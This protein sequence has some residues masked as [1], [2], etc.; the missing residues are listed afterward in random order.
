MNKAFNQ[1]NPFYHDVAEVCELYEKLFVFDDKEA[2]IDLVKNQIIVVS[3]NDTLFE[4]YIFIQMIFQ[5]E[6]LSVN[7]SF[8][9][10]LFYENHNNPVKAELSVSRLE[11]VPFNRI[12]P[13]SF[14]ERLNDNIIIKIHY[15]NVPQ[16]FTDNSYYIRMTKN[17]EYGFR[18]NVRRPD[19]IVE[20]IKDEVS[21]FR[22]IEV[23]N[24]SRGDYIR[25]SFYKVLGYYKDFEGVNLTNSIPFVLVNW[26]GSEIN[27]D[28]EDVVFERDIIIFNKDEFIENIPKLF[29]L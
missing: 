23:K 27:K 11:N 2:L 16:T 8:E 5:L 7:D 1:R 19:L 12:L 24:A 9:M 21:F 28:Y 4:I 26:K 13:N 20:I 18:T 6:E 22:V 29:E 15:Q 3:N 10:G 25:N 17:R 14:R